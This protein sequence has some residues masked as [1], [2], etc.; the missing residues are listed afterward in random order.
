MELRPYQKQA[1]D[2]VLEDLTNLKSCAVISSTGSGKTVIMINAVDRYIKAT[3]KDVLILSHLGLLVKQTKACFERDT[4]LLVGVLQA[5]TVPCALD[6]VIIGTVQSSKELKHMDALLG[7]LEG[8][9]RRIGLIVIDETHR[10][11]CDSYDKVFTALPDAKI[12]GFTAT[13]YKN[14]QLMTDMFEKIS[15]SISLKELIEQ[16]YLVPPVIRKVE[17]VAEQDKKLSQIV[18]VYKEYEPN[19]SA[20]IYM[21]TVK[22]CQALKLLFEAEHVACRVVTGD[23]R[24]DIREKIFDEYKE[25]NVKVLV[26]VDVLSQ[27]FDAP[28]TSSIFLP[29]KVNSPVQWLQRIG[30]GLRTY[31]GKSNCRVYVICDEPSIK[32]GYFQKLEKI[33]K[34]IMRSGDEHDLDRIEQERKTF[35]LDKDV[36]AAYRNLQMSGYKTLAGMVLEQNFPD[37]FME[38]IHDTGFVVVKTLYT[39]KKPI[40]DKQRKLLLNYGFTIDELNKLTLSEASCLIANILNT[41]ERDKWGIVPDGYGKYSGKHCLDLPVSYIH[42]LR[43][44]YPDARILRFYDNYMNNTRGKSWSK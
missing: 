4:S 36:I 42:W 35:N 21:K 44:K 18:A 28:I 17:E 41:S 22:Q 7:K 29:F 20:I 15:F 12:L 24:E 43:L 38:K 1:V 9:T 39:S 37:R 16:G 14:K 5:G 19:G 10:A 8:Y 6:Q 3:G 33:N 13:P 34:E 26:T 2:N 27:G 11:C 31:P 32:K 23:V 25:G 30:R 40:T